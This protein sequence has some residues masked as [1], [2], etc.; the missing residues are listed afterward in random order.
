MLYEYKQECETIELRWD[1]ESNQQTKSK[2]INCSSEVVF[3]PEKMERDIN[4]LSVL[5]FF[6][7][8]GADSKGVIITRILPCSDFY[9]LFVCVDESI[10]MV[11]QLLWFS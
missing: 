1:F 7:L 6:V 5:R 10:E 2:N 9:D 8:E 3:F 4:T 11:K